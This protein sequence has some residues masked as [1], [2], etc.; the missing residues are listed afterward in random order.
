MAEQKFKKEVIA[1]VLDDTISKHDFISQN[2]IT[3][4]ITLAEY[5]ELV[6]TKAISDRKIQESD[7]KRLKYYS[8][9]ITLERENSD[10][11]K[12]L[13]DLQKKREDMYCA[14]KEVS[15]Q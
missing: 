5:R 14:V 13:Y 9:A 2:E 8:K 1:D 10:L 3:V 6:V 7:D 11:K 15:E 12:K 4:T